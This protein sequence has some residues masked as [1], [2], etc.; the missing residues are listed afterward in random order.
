MTETLRDDRPRPRSPFGPTLDD[1]EFRGAMRRF[2][3]RTYDEQE[4]FVSRLNWNL[5]DAQ[6]EAA[7]FHWLGHCLASRAPLQQGFA[8]KLLGRLPHPRRARYATMFGRIRDEVDDDLAARIAEV[9]GPVL[10]GAPKRR[11]RLQEDSKP[12]DESELQQLQEFFRK[13]GRART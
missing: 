13:A 1:V 4:A 9:F 7:F 12:A 6:T 3:G 8:L 2:W 11:K 5:V 10:G